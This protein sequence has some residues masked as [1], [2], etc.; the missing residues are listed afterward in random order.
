MGKTHSLTENPLASTHSL[1]LC[2][3]AAMPVAGADLIGAL[4]QYVKTPVSVALDT[5][6]G[7][8]SVTEAVDVPGARGLMQRS[9]VVEGCSRSLC[10]VVIV[11]A[12]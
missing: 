2:T 4:A 6:D 10:P 9:L 7:T 8:V 12:N 5:A 1:T 11:C 3:A